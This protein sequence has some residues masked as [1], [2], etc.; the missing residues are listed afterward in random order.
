M[1]KPKR[2][3][4]NALWARD[5]AIKA[6]EEIDRL[7]DEIKEALAGGNLYKARVAVAELQRVAARE[8]LAKL[9]AVRASTDC[10][11]CPFWEGEGQE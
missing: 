2:W 5:D 7:G 3:P 10:Q 4:R 6:A 1:T 9:V 11:D 8:I